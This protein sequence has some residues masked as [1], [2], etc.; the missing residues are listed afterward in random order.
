[1]NKPLIGSIDFDNAQQVETWLA[2]FGITIYQLH[3]AVDAVGGD[4][5]AVTEHLVHQGASGGAG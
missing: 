2:Y 4:P 3:E 1:M 5:R